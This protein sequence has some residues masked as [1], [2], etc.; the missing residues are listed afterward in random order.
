MLSPSMNTIT[1]TLKERPKVPLEAESVTPD[2]FVTMSNEQIRASLVYHGKRHCRLDDF[3]EVT[4]EFSDQIEMHGDLHQVKLLGKGM[5][6]GQ[7]KVHG[8]VGMHLGTAMRGGRIEVTGDAGDW[9]GA[10]MTNGVI[11]VHGNGGGQIGAA[12]RGSLRGMRNGTIIIGGTAGLEVGMRMRRGTIVIGGKVRDFC[13][14][15]MKGGTIVLMDGAEIRTGAWMVRGTILSLKPL[16]LMPTFVTSGQYN[17][18][19][20][21]LYARELRPWNITLPN[22]PGTGTWTRHCGDSSIP[23]K[24][25]ILIWN[26]A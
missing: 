14:L 10:E 2:A 22:H 23:G 25:E 6:R 9:I 5:S 1:L 4:G 13:G 8:S 16:P 3:F 7:L 18:T 21:D 19:F 20:I 17:P 12:Y 11:H 26:P 24:G 15:Q